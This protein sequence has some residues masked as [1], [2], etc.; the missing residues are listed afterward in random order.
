MKIYFPIL[1]TPSSIKSKRQASLELKK[2]FIAI[3][4]NISK[5]K[6]KETAVLINYTKWLM[7]NY[8]IFLKYSIVLK[9]P[10]SN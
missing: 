10:S 2:C 4:Y 7:I 9:S 1:I 3:S 8:I 6:K 5:L